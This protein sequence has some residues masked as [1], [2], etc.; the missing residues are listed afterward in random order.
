MNDVTV[1]PAEASVPPTVSAAQRSVLYALRR[2]GEATVE[3]LAASLAITVSGARQH[4]AVLVGAGLVDSS[5]APRRP[6]QRGRSERVFQVTELAEPLFPKA[7]GE[8]TNQLLSYLD[9]EA[10]DQVFDR[11]RDERIEGCPTPD[12]ITSRPSPNASRELAAILDEDGY[13]ASFQER[14]DGTFLVHRAQL[15]HPLGGQRPPARLLQRD[16]VH[17]G[18]AAGGDGGTDHPHDPGRPFV[19]LRG[20]A[21]SLTAGRGDGPS[22]RCSLRCAA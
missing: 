11:R 10:V 18:D 9:R 3:Q 6:G 19:H 4:L 7:Y 16:R 1:D 14:E 2:R 13:L 20:P 8:L 15:R 17:P 12:G 22:T 21:G 5:E